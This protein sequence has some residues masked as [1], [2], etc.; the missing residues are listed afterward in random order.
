MDERAQKLRKI[1][2]IQREMTCPVPFEVFV[3][4]RVEGG[5]QPIGAGTLIAS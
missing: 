2:W 1:T 5:E 3:Q 4:E